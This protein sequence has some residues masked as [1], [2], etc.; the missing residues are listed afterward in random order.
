MVDG[1]EPRYSAAGKKST[2][3]TSTGSSPFTLSGLSFEDELI[4]T[5]LC[6]MAISGK[7][8]VSEG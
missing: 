8:L 5:R 2:P 3:E 7:R 1:S 4:D 6:L